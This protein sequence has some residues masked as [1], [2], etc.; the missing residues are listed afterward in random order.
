M[1]KTK[2]SLRE[3]TR[4]GSPAK[5]A[6]PGKAPPGLFPIVGVGASA[7][8]LD[9]FERLLKRLP[10]DTG[11]AF[12]LVEHVDPKHESRLKAIFS[13]SSI[14]R[15][16]LVGRAKRFLVMFVRA[17]STHGRFGSFVR[18]WALF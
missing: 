7:G 12:V 13:R 1:A 8:G 2:Q 11:M 3:K 10:A 6:K 17:K 9:A 14:T 15:G 4:R 18:H 16:S 5:A